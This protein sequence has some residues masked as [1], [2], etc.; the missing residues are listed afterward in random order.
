MSTPLKVLDGDGNPKYIDTYDTSAGTQANPLKNST[1]V[2]NF[3]TNFAIE[4][5]GNLASIVSNTANT[6]TYGATTASNTTSIAS[7]STTI[8][9]NSTA[10]SGATG[11]VS[12]NSWSGSGNGTIIG[13][14][15]GLYN[16]LST[17]AGS[18]AG[19]KVQANITNSSI[20]VTG[21]F[22]PTTQPVS[23]TITANAGTNLNTSLLALETGGNLTTIATAQGAGGTGISQPTGGSGVLGW[24]SGIYS[25][26]SGTLT[27]SGSVN[28]GNTVPVTGTFWQTTQP[29]SAS[30]LPLPT[31]AAQESG[32]LA[33]L[34]GAVTA[35]K[36]QANITN[37]SIP[38]T[39]TFYQTT[40]P[41][42]GTITANAGTNLNTS[43]LALETG[44]NLTTIA[45]AVSAGKIQANITNSSVPVTGTFWQTT[46]P[47]TTVP[48][49]TNGLTPYRSLPTGATNQDSTVIKSSAGTLFGIQA[50]SIAS[51]AVWLK[52]YDTAT[53]PTSSS[54]PV[55]TILI[56][57]NTT[58]ANGAGNN[59]NL[60][61]MG[62]KF[63]SGIAFRVSTGISDSDATAVTTGT[64]AINFD[65][66]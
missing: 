57:A 49:T 46:Q 12:D 37:S 48:S 61:T 18:V 19:G 35:G 31:G 30:S 56:P 55:K 38:V 62:V 54:T 14:L 1:Y 9:S 8:A 6:A 3:P 52:L 23:G 66:V 41:V 63:T 29:V 11:T 65:Y 33:T 7:S 53:A 21:T 20:P 50:S 51:S 45:G 26:I 39:G 17:L 28:V 2:Q 34:A 47:M 10:I 58:S 15:K 16:F 32:N 4:S 36:V 42:S 27:V 59:L 44:G 25:K 24:L 43:L 22:Y 64:L 40:Q 13:V 5:G 60:S